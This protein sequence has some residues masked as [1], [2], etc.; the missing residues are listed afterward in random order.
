MIFVPRISANTASLASRLNLSGRM[1]PSSKCEV[2]TRSIPA[3][4]NIPHALLPDTSHLLSVLPLHLQQVTSFGEETTIGS[5]LGL[6][7][8]T[9]V[10]PACIMRTAHLAQTGLP[11]T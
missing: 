3:S 8:T 6:R 5:S 11:D 9:R 2:S 4:I 10:M 1:S 7:A